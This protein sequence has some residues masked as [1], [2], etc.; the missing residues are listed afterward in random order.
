LDSSFA[1]DDGVED[2][3]HGRVG[4]V[5]EGDQK[6]VSWKFFEAATFASFAHEIEKLTR[7]ASEVIHFFSHVKVNKYLSMSEFSRKT[8][9]HEPQHASGK[10]LFAGMEAHETGYSA[11][12]RVCLRRE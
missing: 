11:V 8:F 10:K 5:R 12:A 4:A 9:E 6:V 2:F 7:N 1:T 3:H